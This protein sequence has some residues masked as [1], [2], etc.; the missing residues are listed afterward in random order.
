MSV[1]VTRTGPET[2]AGPLPLPPSQSTSLAIGTLSKEQTLTRTLTAT[3][4][5][6]YTVSA[7]VPGVD[8]T[9]SPSTLTFGA[10]GEAQSFEVT[11]S[12][13]TAPVEEWA[14]G[15]LTWTDGTTGVRSPI[16]VRPVT[17]DA[18]AEVP[19]DVRLLVVG[20]PNHALSMPRPSTRE[21]AMKQYGAEVADPSALF[22]GHG[23]PE[24]GT[25]VAIALEGRRALPVEVQ[26]LTIVT[27][28]PNPR[29]M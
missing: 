4:P 21:G 2:Y 13:A 23:S 10:A 20:G 19:G 18:P 15:S 12:N 5:G 16:A 11:F 24:P 25:C 26:A 27:S 8:V 9:V 7:E 14:T 22:L 28:A 3:A 1:P 6:T 17:A 29:R